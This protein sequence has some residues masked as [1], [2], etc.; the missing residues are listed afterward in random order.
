MDRFFVYRPVFGWVIAAFIALGGL[1]ALSTLLI[2]QS[3]SVAPPS[4]NLSY[5][6]PAPMRR[7]S[8]ET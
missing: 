5:A 4:L 6:I 8:T 3:P 7:R 1:L 2:E